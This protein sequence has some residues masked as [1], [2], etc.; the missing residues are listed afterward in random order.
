L[1]ENTRVGTEVMT[2]EAYPRRN[3]NIQALDGVSLRY[4]MYMFIT[5]PAA[6]C[7][8]KRNSILKKTTAQMIPKW[9]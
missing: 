8:Q 4:A 5:L 7:N 2:L 3:F 9:K 6:Y 1:S